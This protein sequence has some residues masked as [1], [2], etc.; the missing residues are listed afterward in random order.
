M[1]KIFYLTL[2]IALIAQT[3]CAPT[4]SDVLKNYE[5][6]FNGKRDQFKSIAHS[7]SSKGSV[8]SN[9]SCKEV[10]PA[11]VFNEKNKQYNTEI[12]M[13]EQLLDPDAVPE[14]DLLLSNDLLLAIQWT[15]SKSPLSPSVLDDSGTDM[16]TSLKAA[17]E[18]RYLV[19]NRVVKL[20]E[21]EV[22][23][24]KNYF[25]GQVIIETFVADMANNKTLCSF[26]TSAN[27]PSDLT[28]IPISTTTSYTKRGKIRFR[29]ER[30]AK[31]AEPEAVQLKKAASSIMW[32]EAR[33]NMMTTLGNHT[34]AD[35]ELE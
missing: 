28:N 35:I 7:L 24:E 9:T 5:S 29:T 30:V 27:S 3:G 14:M 32:E 25:Q 13:F 34:N 18:Y 2:F 6:E 8:K 4:V 16:E 33:R 15:G 21:P 19:I 17:L 11:M 26:A 23:D 12:I 20:I 1:K 31:Y 10:A 22:L